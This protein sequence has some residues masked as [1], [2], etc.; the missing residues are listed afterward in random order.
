MKFLKLNFII[1][2]FFLLTF[3]I[4]GM[5]P[6]IRI[7]I[8]DGL[9]ST[10]IKV[11]KYSPSTGG[12]ILFDS[13][14]SVVNPDSNSYHAWCDID[15]TN[16]DN[17]TWAPLSF[18]K[19]YLIKIYNH[20]C[21][22]DIDTNKSGGPDFDMYFHYGYFSEIN[23]TGVVKIV[24]QGT[25]SPKTITVNNS[26]NAGFL[27]VDDNIESSGYN[28]GL[29][30][31]TFPHK[32]EA[33]DNHTYDN[34]IRKFQLWT[35][36]DE[37]Y[38]NDL[39]IP[40]FD[41]TATYE[42]DFLK[43]FDIT[44]RNS[45]VSVGN[46]GTIKVEG[47]TVSSPTSTE[48]VLQTN[49]I[50]FEALNQT[51]NG[52]EY[53]FDEWENSS[54]SKSRTETPEDHEDYVAS[55][56]G[57]PVGV[58]NSL[59]FNSGAPDGTP[60][61]LYW[62]DN[63]NSTVQYKIYRKHGK[64]GATYLI[65]T[66]NSGVETYTDYDMEHTSDTSTDNLTS[67]DV[68]AYYPTESSSAD[69]DFSTLYAELLPKQ[70]NLKDDST[71]AHTSVEENS[72]TNFPNPFNPTTIVYYRLKERGNVVIKVYDTLGKEVAVLINETKP[73][74]EYVTKFNG[75]NLSSGIYIMTMQINNFSISKKI[76]LTK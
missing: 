47:S 68:R 9:Y 37:F 57:K 20:Y 19:T 33:Y 11:Y 24:G 62:D 38:D 61:I 29:G 30:S 45:F 35:K 51:I 54:T 25:W 16:S 22:L 6:E 50:S 4:Y 28:E 40:I 12:Y 7:R 73:M 70:N 14:C 56:V 44:F 10:E 36:N 34:Y 41:E 67:Y 55:F 72:I 39:D 66:K 26:Y 74:G 15:D 60:V 52:I 59:T 42:A 18:D 17:P 75:S 53:T 64:F 5:L 32:L 58:G 71:Y 63:V 27:K 21:I 65:A 13:G 23:S 49:S 76:L 46:G 43:E 1:S 31:P 48:H 8:N 69:A 3:T 2:I